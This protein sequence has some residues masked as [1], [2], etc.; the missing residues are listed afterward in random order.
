MS[1]AGRLGAATKIKRLR[2]NGKYYGE[3]TLGNIVW[4]TDPVDKTE[5]ESIQGTARAMAE[6]LIEIRKGK[7]K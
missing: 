2:S 4:R 3:F 1:A 6:R 7:G 5:I